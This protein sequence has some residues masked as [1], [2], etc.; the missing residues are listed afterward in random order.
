ME[1]LS[2]TVK[3]IFQTIVEQDRKHIVEFQKE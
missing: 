2:Q 1:C 3:G